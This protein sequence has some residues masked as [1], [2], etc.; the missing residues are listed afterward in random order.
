MSRAF[1]RRLD[2][3]EDNLIIGP[4]RQAFERERRHF[5]NMRFIPDSALVLLFRADLGE[6]KV[7]KWLQSRLL[8]PIP[9]DAPKDLVEEATASAMGI[10]AAPMC[11]DQDILRNLDELVASTA[12][13]TGRPIRSLADVQS[14]YEELERERA[15]CLKN[16]A[17]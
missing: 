3:L 6:I 17:V 9:V 13:D 10:D 7:P 16:G 8:K 11:E 14:Y 15:T 4:E 5:Y 1:I 2:K 12:K